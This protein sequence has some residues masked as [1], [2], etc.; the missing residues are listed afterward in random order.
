MTE[1]NGLRLAYRGL[2][3]GL[4]GAY[5]WVALAMSGAG[6]LLGDPLQPLRPIAALLSPVMAGSPELAFV[7][8]LGLVQAAGGVIGMCFAY[9]FGRFFTVRATVAVAALA[10][11]A[12]AWALVAVGAETLRGVAGLT[13]S[14]I[15]ILATLGYGLL[16]GLGLPLRGEVLR[17]TTGPPAGT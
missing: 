12:L 13:A 14:P 16:L 11:A 3:G 7:V 1:V 8:G 10:F 9:F 5:A 4:A 2:V 6:L 15:P 17:S